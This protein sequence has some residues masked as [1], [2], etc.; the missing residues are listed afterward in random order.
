MYYAALPTAWAAGVPAGT[1]M[2][3]IGSATVWECGTVEF[4]CGYLEFK[5]DGL[6]TLERALDRGERLLAALG[7]RLLEPAKRAGEAAE[8]VELR[9]S[10]E[11]SV[12]ASLARERGP[13]ADRC[14]ALGL[15]VAQR[16]ARAGRGP[17]DWH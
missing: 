14:A 12:L 10:S 16:R 5:G 2:P 11:S 15:L 8:A 6:E 17:G 9:Q 1:H 4:R 7:S 3:P 13:L